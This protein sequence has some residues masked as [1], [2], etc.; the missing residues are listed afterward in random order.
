MHRMLVVSLIVAAAL[1]TKVQLA[2]AQA[3][4]EAKGKVEAIHL[5]A[6]STGDQR[7]WIIMALIL[8]MA[9]LFLIL[10]WWQKRIEQAGYFANIFH[11]SI[12]TIETNR[13]SQPHQEKWLQDGYWEEIAIQPSERGQRWLDQDK[14]N[15]RPEPKPELEKLAKTLGG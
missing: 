11:D 10:F 1:L 15:K 4:E 6:I 13:L 7:F 14:R 3:A 2:I 9:F 5:P 12:A 8:L